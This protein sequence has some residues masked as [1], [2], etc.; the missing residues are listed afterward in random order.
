MYQIEVKRWL[1]EYL[2]RARDGWVVT[3]DIDAMEKGKG[4]QHPPGKS[5]VADQQLK[6]MEEHGVTIGPHPVHG[7]TDVVAEHVLHGTNLIEVEGDTTK[8]KEQSI[9]SALGQVILMMGDQDN[10]ITFGLAVPDDDSWESQLSKIPR[11][12]CELLNLKLWLVSEGGV[13]EYKDKRTSYC[14]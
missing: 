7:R 8:Q 12:I 2:L 5:E 14:T 3:V 10:D 1:I 13:R 6:W 4:G 9:Y 11:R